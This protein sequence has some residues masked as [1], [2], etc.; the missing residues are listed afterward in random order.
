MIGRNKLARLFDLNNIQGREQRTD[1]L[2]RR[3]FSVS[4]LEPNVSFN[5]LSTRCDPLVRP[6]ELQRHCAHNYNNQCIG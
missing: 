3:Y 5:W 1:F 4:V 2:S 6:I